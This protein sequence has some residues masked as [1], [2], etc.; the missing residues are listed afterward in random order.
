MGRPAASRIPVPSGNGVAPVPEPRLE[1]L[2]GGVG[3]G[4]FDVLLI[5]SSFEQA[6]TLG[7]IL[8]GWI[9]HTGNLENIFIASAILALF[10]LVVAWGIS[11]PRSVRSLVLPAAAY[12]FLCVFPL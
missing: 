10:W 7:G 6:P 11:K 4:R 12:R 9:G 5:R 2:G 8:G 3:A 1:H